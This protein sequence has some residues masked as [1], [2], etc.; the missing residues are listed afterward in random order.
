D[1]IDEHRGNDRR[2]SV[3]RG[4]GV[5]EVVLA[6]ALAPRHD[7]DERALTAVGEPLTHER[8]ASEIDLHAVDLQAEADP[9]K[10]TREA[11]GIVRTPRWPDGKRNPVHGAFAVDVE[12]RLAPPVVVDEGVPKDRLLQRNARGRLEAQLLHRQ[13][14]TEDLR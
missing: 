3:E 7:A 5:D 8:V 2:G 10:V 9:D 1:R 6:R 14:R 11:G 4:H 12:E 13:R